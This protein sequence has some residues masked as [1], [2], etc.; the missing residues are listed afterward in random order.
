MKKVPPI[1]LDKLSRQRNHQGV[2]GVMSA[3]EYQNIENVVPFIFEKGEMPLILILDGVTDVRNMGAICRSAEVMGVHT[4]V[5]PV[6]NSAEINEDAI[7]TSAGALMSLPVCRTAHLPKVISYLKES[8]ISIT[9]SSLEGDLP[10]FDLDMSGPMA[11]I[12]GSEQNGV[13]KTLMNLSDHIFKIPQSGKTD[14]LNVS[15][16]T[17]VILYE[18]VR[19]RMAAL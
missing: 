4:V 2:V 5:L 15:V 7:K 11:I 18:C 10:I 13:D 1:K 3:I 16:A 12:M 9:C 8:G 6:Q 14:S 17:G 19:Q